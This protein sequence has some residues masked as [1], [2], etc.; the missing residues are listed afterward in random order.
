M[1]ECC[2]CAKMEDANTSCIV[3]LRLHGVGVGGVRE[4]LHYSINALVSV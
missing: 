4:D 1:Q 2:D 3:Q